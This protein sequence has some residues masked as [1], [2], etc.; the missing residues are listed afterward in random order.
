[1]LAELAFEVLALALGVGDPRGSDRHGIFVV[2]QGAVVGELAVA[3]G[4]GSAQRGFSFLGG[5]V[6][7]RDAGEALAGVVDVVIVE[8]R[9]EPFVEARHDGLFLDVDVAGVLPVDVG[10]VLGE[11]AAVVRTAV[12]PVSLHPPT[13][14]AAPHPTGED[15]VPV[16]RL[17]AA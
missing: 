1:M 9:R 2:E 13:A 16:L 8:Q 5:G 7:F 12:A 15:V 3:V 11:F 4:N 14:D 17:A 6:G 10:V